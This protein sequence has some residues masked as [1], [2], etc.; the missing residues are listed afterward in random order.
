[1]FY[2]Q[3]IRQKFWDVLILMRQFDRILILCTLS[4][5]VA[6]CGDAD[7]PTIDETIS[8]E[9]LAAEWPGFVPSEDILRAAQ[10]GA[11]LDEAAIAALIY[12][13]RRL[14][15]RAEAL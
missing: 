15:A 9:A 2:C 13:A 5:L 7:L 12:R 11:V 4:S 8:P 3:E 14:K 1:M 10:E 6:G